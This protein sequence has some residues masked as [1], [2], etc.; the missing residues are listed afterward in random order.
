M[1]GNTLSPTSGIKFK[2]KVGYALG[3]T[4]GV[5][6]FALMG[7]YLQLFYTNVLQISAARIVVLM[8]IARIWDGINDP[9]WGT[10]IDRR[11]PGP[12]G[13][14]RPYLKWVSLP[15]AIVG[16]LVFVKIPGLSE[17]Q[18]LIYAYVTYIMYDMMY[19]G[20][21]IPYGSLASMITTD[22]L[23]R[24]DLSVFR[25]L[26]AGIGGLPAQ[27]LLPLVVYS[28]VVDSAGKRVFDEAGNAQKYLDGNKLMLA[29]GLLAAISVI[30]YLASYKLTKERVKSAPI[31]EKAD[32]WGTVRI[33]LRNRPFITLCLASMF[34][35]ATQQYTQTL[36]NYLFLDYFKRPELYSLVT[37]FTY[38]PMALLIPFMK[39]LVAR[40]GKKELCAYGMALS[41]VAT[42]LL[43][44]LKTNS[45]PVFFALCFLC[46][47]GMTFFIMEIWALVTDIIDYQEYLSGR[48]EEGTSYAFFSFTR[49]IGQTIAGSLGAGV[50]GLIGYDASQLTQTPQVLD[51]LY[52][53]STAIPAF[54]CAM[55][56]VIL[57]FAYPLGKEQ[58]ARLHS[59]KKS[60]EDSQ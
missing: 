16:F 21:N 44:I 4:A 7:S 39:K 32:V 49:K 6:T 12:N 34:L 9:I 3:D 22:E 31:K 2:E 14:F 26:G 13:K 1:S 56:A 38:L 29:V 15:L 25:S 10:I 36:Y 30:V 23:E 50:I 48:R 20:I 53:A 43:W 45:I 40:F 52:T 58:L 5:F 51:K 27:I 37:V 17:T 19:T 28:Y 41:T 11:S 55:M 24:S 54:A 8:L 59:D 18:Y 46:G 57:W 42:A 47:L 60:L 35:I 33:L